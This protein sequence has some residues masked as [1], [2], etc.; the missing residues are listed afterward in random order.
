MKK[1]PENACLSTWVVH[2]TWIFLRWI[3][4]PWRTFFEVMLVVTLILH[5]WAN[6]YHFHYS[7]G[8]PKS[9]LKRITESSLLDCI[10]MGCFTKEVGTHRITEGNTNPRFGVWA[11]S[12][13]KFVTRVHH[14]QQMATNLVKSKVPSCSLLNCIAKRKKKLVL[15]SMCET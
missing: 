7:N 10:S 9:L 5:I 12:L 14:H 8:S 1:T 2:F 11:F 13:L 15:K 6:C 4:L 3:S